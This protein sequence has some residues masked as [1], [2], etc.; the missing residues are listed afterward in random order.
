MVFGMTWYTIPTLGCL[1]NGVKHATNISN[2]QI[3]ETVYTSVRNSF[4]SLL[5]FTFSVTYIIP[6]GY[7]FVKVTS[8]H[9]IGIF[10]SVLWTSFSSTADVTFD[11]VDLILGSYHSCYSSIW[12]VPLWF[13]YMEVRACS[14]CLKTSDKRTLGLY[15]TH[16][17]IILWS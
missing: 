10:L 4:I 6:L 8:R 13:V 14:I 16:V 15:I 2:I 7:Y 5:P 17:H 11:H 12:F 1:R 9:K 3:T